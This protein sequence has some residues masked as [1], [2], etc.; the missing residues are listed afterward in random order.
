MVLLEPSDLPDLMALEQA[1]EVAVS[2]PASLSAALSSSPDEMRHQ[3]F[4]AR[5]E[6]GRLLGYAM[7][8]LQPFD[9]E[10]EAILVA[11]EARRQGIAGRLLDRVVTAA[12]DQQLERLLLEVRAGNQAAIALYRAAGFQLDGVR[13]GYYPPGPAAGAYPPGPAASSP[14][15]SSG[16]REDAW[17]MSLDLNSC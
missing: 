13:K 11:S 6:E 10:L 7:L 15:A 1:Q 4:G 3:V 2:T 9:A 12:R 17:L 5:S 14:T 16:L 8:A